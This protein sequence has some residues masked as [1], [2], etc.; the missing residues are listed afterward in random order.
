MRTFTRHLG[1]W[2]KVAIL[3]K[4]AEGCDAT[5]QILAKRKILP[6]RSF[7]PLPIAMDEYRSA[8]VVSVGHF[9]MIAGVLHGLEFEI[10]SGR[11]LLVAS[12]VASFD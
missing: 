3:S 1:F 9:P 4:V 12:L 7:A 5:A 10:A 6:N 2:R 8:Q 11:N